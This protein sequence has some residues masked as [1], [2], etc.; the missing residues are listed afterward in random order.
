MSLISV[1][2]TRRYWQN[3]CK[4]YQVIDVMSRKTF[5]QIKKYLHFSDNSIDTGVDKLGKIRPI[6]DKLREN[7]KKNTHG[8]KHIR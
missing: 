2:G 1:P 3:K 8:R 7:M 6:V 4:I 5:E